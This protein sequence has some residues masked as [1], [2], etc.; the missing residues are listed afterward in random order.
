VLPGSARDLHVEF[1]P[2][3]NRFERGHRI[4]LSVVGT[5]FTFQPS[6][7][8]LNSI[9]VGGGSGARLQLP[10]LPGSDLCAALGAA[11]CP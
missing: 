1:W 8:A 10:V 7:P 3:G 2:V 5:P 6:V 4:R 9:V 11:P